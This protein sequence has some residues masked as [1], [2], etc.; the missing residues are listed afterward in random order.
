[1]ASVPNSQPDAQQFSPLPVGTALPPETRLPSP[2]S[3]AWSSPDW[4]HYVAAGTVIAGGVLIA[5]GHRRAGMAVAATG[6]GMA[7][8]E[9]QE[10]VKSWW[11]NVPAFLAEAQ[12]F[13]DK[14]DGYLK[15]ATVQ[16]QR[17]QGI[18]RRD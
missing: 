13:L 18:L 2:A 17:L 8:L 7:L 11:K 9:E 6:A 12:V 1:M 14:V 15:E 3:P 5:T 10:A 16:G 4:T